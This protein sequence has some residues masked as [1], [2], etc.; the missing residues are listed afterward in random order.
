MEFKTKRLVVTGLILELVTYFQ[1]RAKLTVGRGGPTIERLE[2]RVPSK[3]HCAG[4]L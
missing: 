1:I 2:Q 4:L 3:A